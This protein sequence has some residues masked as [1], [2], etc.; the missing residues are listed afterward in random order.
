MKSI[1]ISGRRLRQILPLFGGPCEAIGQSLQHV[2]VTTVFRSMATDS[3][4]PNMA[5]NF[6]FKSIRS[7]AFL[8]LS[9]AGA[10]WIGYEVV[11]TNRQQVAQCSSPNPGAGMFRGDLPTFTKQEVSKHR[12]KDSGI[13]VTY[14]D[15]VY[16]VTQWADIHPG[17]AQRL[18][19]AAGAAIDP[20]WAMYA[21]H[22]TEQVKEIL[23][24]YRIGN[25]EG[26][27]A[28][29]GDPYANEPKDRHPSLSVRS[30]TPLNAETP[31]ELLAEA[32]IT[33][34]DLFY[35]RNHL[36]VPD[37][38]EKEYKLEVGGDGVKSV[39]LS[40]EDLKTKFKKHTVVATVQCAGNRRKDLMEGLY[41]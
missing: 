37:I 2:H 1:R 35:I 22:N 3:A 11:G 31:M 16:D 18:M 4:G 23:E 33:P 36:P 20:F 10:S 27:S 15:G 25:L 17:G 5:N 41:C 26:G 9:V 13:W 32:L 38:D 24:E 7:L 6:E 30:R 21:Q 8:G 12:T 29:V 28:P 14:K 39:K 34:N 19:L 40:L